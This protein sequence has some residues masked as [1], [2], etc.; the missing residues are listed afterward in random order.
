MAQ[1]QNQTQGQIEKEIE[2]EILRTVLKTGH[3]IVTDYELEEH[4]Y[5]YELQDEPGFLDVLKKFEIHK[6]GDTTYYSVLAFDEKMKEYV[7]EIIDLTVWGN[8]DADIID[9]YVEMKST[10]CTVENAAAAAILDLAR[11]YF[12]VTTVVAEKSTKYIVRDEEGEVIGAI[13]EERYYCNSC[14]NIDAPRGFTFVELCTR[15]SLI[16]QKYVRSR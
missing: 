15:Y 16:A 2:K 8:L 9:Q 4:S 13:E 1:V 14:M 7:R 3:Y 5:L 10:S 6:R 11:K 12:D